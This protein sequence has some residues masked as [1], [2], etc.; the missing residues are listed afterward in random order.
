MPPSNPTDDKPIVLVVD[1]EQTTAD[2][3]TEFLADMY[4]VRTA[5]SGT[6]AL[7]LMDS[8]VDVVLLD[9]RMP[10]LS[11][12]EVLET[13]RERESDFRTIMVTAVSPD[14]DIIDLPFDEYLVKPVSME[15]LD[16]AIDRMLIRTTYDAKIQNLMS[17]ASKMAT[18]ESKLELSDLTA[19]DE[20]V[21]LETE[22]TEM[23]EELG[24][25]AREVDP[26][27]EFTIE[28]I[29]AVIGSG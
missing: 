29:R 21:A 11:G 22:F 5:Y 26:Y 20:Y 24:R 15:T 25:E 12:D 1:D 7:E 6:E 19:S 8:T 23:R 9:R 2:L 17:L 27:P 28:K 13:M 18:L 10:G 3:Y 16:D 14:L 4:S